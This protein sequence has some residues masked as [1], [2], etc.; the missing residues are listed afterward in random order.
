MST[1]ETCKQKGDVIIVLDSS[2]SIGKDN[3]AMHRNFI[4]RFTENFELGE[5]G[6]KFGV[7]VFSFNAFKLFDLKDYNTRDSLRQVTQIPL[8]NPDIPR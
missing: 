8:G 2:G 5:D 3:F 6:F 4:Q 1:V 7:V